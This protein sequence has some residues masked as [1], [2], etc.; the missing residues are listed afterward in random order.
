MAQLLELLRKYNYEG[1]FIYRS[2]VCNGE[3]DAQAADEGVVKEV[4]K[5]N[6][7]VLNVLPLSLCRGTDLN[8]DKIHFDLHFASKPP[9]GKPSLGELNAQIIQSLLNGICNPILFGS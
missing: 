2:N 5:A 8:R 9:A 7:S 6:Y 1:Q 4:R 3:F